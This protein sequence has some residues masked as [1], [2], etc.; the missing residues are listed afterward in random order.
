[1]R[2][3]L[4]LL[5]RCLFVCVLIIAWFAPPAQAAMLEVTGPTDFYFTYSEPSLFTARAYAAEYGID[6]HL[7]FYD[8]ENN[9][10]AANDDWF[11]LDSWLSIA[12]QPGT[13]RLRAGVCCG[14][15]TY[16]YGSG[17]QLDVNSDPLPPE[18]TTT[19]TFVE[20]TTTTTFVEESTTTT[21][22]P[23]AT[24]PVVTEPETTTTVEQ[25]TTTIEETTTSAPSP[26]SKPT[27]PPEDTW[28]P[29]TAS[30]T[31]TTTPITTAPMTTVPV[32][33]VPPSTEISTP[34]SPPLTTPAVTN[35]VTQ[36][37]VTAP[38][39]TR[40]AQ[41]ADNGTTTTTT[42]AVVNFSTAPPQ[43]AP[44]EVRQKFENSVDLFS[45]A[46]DNYVP[47]GSTIS[48]AQRRVVIAAT[49]VLF[50][51]PVPTS[52]RKD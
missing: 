51:I 32:T 3:K 35:A 4:G 42:T 45:G 19:T 52:R 9:L 1:M 34:S 26:P 31:P 5:S 8:S 30:T 18:T 38:T 50:I 29:T 10:L 14:D 25:T 48:I 23:V 27:N 6:S 28:P 21:E 49:A 37:P 16:W 11:G 33:S 7:W 17:Y 13:Y 15:P 44:L 47:I 41:S 2:R 46:Y 22:Q 20:E 24:D 36:A 39:A 12:V 40:P 43:D